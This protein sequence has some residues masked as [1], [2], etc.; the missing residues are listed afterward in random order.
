MANQSDIDT[1]RA[2][3]DAALAALDAA[4]NAV[5]AELE[6]TTAPGPKQDALNAR[7]DA[8]D[9]Q[10]A[11]IVTAATDQVLGL[12]SVVAA[13]GQLAMLSAEMTTEAKKL[14][15]ATDVLKATA[16]VLALGQKF[17]EM[18]KKT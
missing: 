8:L 4:Y 7:Y 16:S 14:T 18:L 5:G 12:P 15:G 17:S 3:R 1:I 9:A 6:Q 2:N 10:R 11:A 13:A